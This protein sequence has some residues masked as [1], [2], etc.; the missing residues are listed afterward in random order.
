MI[1]STKLLGR[2][3]I[4]RETMIF[5]FEK[6]AGFNFRP[7][8]FIELKLKNL[9]FV[10]EKG[11]VYPFSIVS[12]PAEQ[13][14]AIATR[15]RNSAFKNSLRTLALGSEVEIDG[16]FG[17]FILHN[18]AAREAVILTGGIGITPFRSM[19]KH[20]VETRLSH[21]ILLFHSNRHPDDAAFL[22]ELQDLESKNSNF[23]FVPT[24]TKAAEFDWKGERGYIDAAMIKKYIDNLKNPVYYIAGPPAFV[25]AMW[26]MLKLTG[27]DSN[28]IKTEDFAGY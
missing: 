10:D 15:M 28:N 17:S 24:M 12:T 25:Q 22:R 4:A 1:H 8:Q 9:P 6:P 18:D 5:E 27:V 21:K 14:L 11:S 13:Q 19:T 3:V 7:G 23:K 2:R 20:A 26:Q 16:P